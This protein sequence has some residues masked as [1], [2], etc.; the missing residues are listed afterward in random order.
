MKYSLS[1]SSTYSALEGIKRTL[2]YNLIIGLGGSKNIDH[3]AHAYGFAGRMILFEHMTQSTLTWHAAGGGITAALF[4]L[5]DLKR[6]QQMAMLEMSSRRSSSLMNKVTA[7]SPWQ[8]LVML[9]RSIRFNK[10]NPRNSSYNDDDY[11][12][13]DYYRRDTVFVPFWPFLLQKS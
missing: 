7:S 3:F 10:K 13:A 8:R 11:V 1:Y 2:L 5:R 4:V 12:Y 6:R 9:F